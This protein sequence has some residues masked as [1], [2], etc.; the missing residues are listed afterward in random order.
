MRPEAH[1]APCRGRG[2]MRPEAHLAPCRGRGE[3]RPEAHLAPCRGR[4]VMWRELSGTPALRV[5]LQP[6]LPLLF[7]VRFVSSDALVLRSEL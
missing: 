6:P 7:G 3:M 1:L 2:E 5:P 4:K